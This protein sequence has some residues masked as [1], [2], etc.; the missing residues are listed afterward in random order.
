MGKHT[1][2]LA[3]ETD[4]ARVGIFVGLPS[5]NSATGALAVLYRATPSRSVSCV[6]MSSLPQWSSTVATSDRSARFVVVSDGSCAPPERRRGQLAGGRVTAQHGAWSWQEAPQVGSSLSAA[7]YSRVHRTWLHEAGRSCVHGCAVLQQEP[8]RCWVNAW[9]NAWGREVGCSW[10]A[11]SRDP[12]E[13]E[14]HLRR[15]ELVLV[16]GLE[17]HGDPDGGARPGRLAEHRDLGRVDGVLLGVGPQPPDCRLAGWESIRGG[18]WC[19][20]ACFFCGARSLAVLRLAAYRST[21]VLQVVPA[22]KST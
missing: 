10:L 19:R 6:A 21:S 15:G 22:S 8:G 17:Q 4:G 1:L 12:C 2:C 5:R 20:L 14:P 13:A 11:V 3:N 7:V 16:V 9:V 18:Q